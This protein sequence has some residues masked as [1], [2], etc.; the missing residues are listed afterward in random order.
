MIFHI[1]GKADRYDD[2]IFGH[3]ETME[4]MPELDEN[5]DSNRTMFSDAEAAAKRPFYALQKPVDD[6]LN[7]HMSLFRS[8]SSI[9]KIIVIGHS[10]NKIDLPYFEEIARQAPDANWTVCI[11]KPEEKDPAI[12][13]LSKCGVPDGKIDICRYMDLED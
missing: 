13:A 12:Q 5:G 6:V 4:E 11:Y 8:L 1:H 9:Q 7:E 10:L 3:G 2:L